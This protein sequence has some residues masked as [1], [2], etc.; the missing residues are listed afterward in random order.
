MI[1]TKVVSIHDDSPCP[2]VGTIT[3]VGEGDHS[4]E[5]L[6]LWDVDD[7]YVSS[8]VPL[9]E[10]MPHGTRLEYVTIVEPTPIHDSV[11]RDMPRLMRRVG[12]RGR[13]LLTRLAS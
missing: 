12:R 8:I 10:L 9:D 6:V 7:R 5:A 13:H 1:G 11:V 2:V 4:G 3:C